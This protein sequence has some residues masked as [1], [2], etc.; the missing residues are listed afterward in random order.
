MNRKKNNS[1]PMNNNIKVMLFNTALFV[2][3]KMKS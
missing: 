2:L 3:N 1:I